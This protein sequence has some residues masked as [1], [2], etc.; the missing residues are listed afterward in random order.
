[1]TCCVVGCFL[2]KSE[3][4]NILKGVLGVNLKKVVNPQLVTMGLGVFGATFLATQLGDLLE[5]QTNPLVVDYRRELVGAAL[6]I[7]GTML[8]SGGG[9]ELRS[10]GMAVG[11]TGVASVAS[12]LA[13][14]LTDGSPLAAGTNNGNGTVNLP[15]GGNFS[16]GGGSSGGSS[17][18]SGNLSG[19]YYLTPY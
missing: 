17:S 11:A 8:M 16:I 4:E 18:G 5:K 19:G 7:G 9:R 15:S 1:M 13:R 2:V 14:R 12:G 10:V 6:T 3:R